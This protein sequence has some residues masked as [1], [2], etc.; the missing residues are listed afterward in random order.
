M[1]CDQGEHLAAVCTFDA[2]AAAF[3]AH[4]GHEH[5]DHCHNETAENAGLRCADGYRLRF[6]YAEPPDNV[7]DHNAERKACER[8]HGVV[9]VKKTGN[10][11][12]VCISA[13][14]RK[15]RNRGHGLDQRRDD[16]NAEQHK[17]HRR[18]KLSD[19]GE[20]LPWLQ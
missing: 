14:R 15:L 4:D 11:G 1:A 5:I 6:F 12:V 2:C 18:E 9:A 17:E 19:I 20:D 8:I 7:D 13:Q 3:G 10:E 16:K